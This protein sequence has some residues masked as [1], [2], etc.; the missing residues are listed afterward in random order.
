[1]KTTGLQT[2]TKTKLN[3][4]LW[5]SQ[6]DEKI[7]FNNLLN[8]FNIESLRECFNAIDGRKAVGIDGVTKE[9]YAKDLE[10]NLKTL[11]EGIHEMGYRP[12]PVRETLIPKEG[13]P[14]ATRPL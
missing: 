1:M 13:K 12:A 5:L 6:Q 3:R 14:G 10:T 11:V 2:G 4:I 7:K 8:L 9:D